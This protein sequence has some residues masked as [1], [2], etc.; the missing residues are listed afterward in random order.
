[1]RY[2]SNEITE[3]IKRFCAG[4][5]EAFAGIYEGTY[6]LVY[7]TCYG[8]IR[9]KD[10]A[11]DLTQDVFVQIYE[12]LG[13]LK[14]PAA[15]GKWMKLVAS[16]RAINF[17]NRKSRVS[18]VGDDHELDEAVSDW[19]EFDSLPDSFIEEEEKRD[20]INKV[21]KES[22]SDVQYQTLFMF[23][24]G[25]MPLAKIA[26]AMNCPEGTVKTR[27]LHAKNKFKRSL[28]GYLD[29]NRLVLAAVPFMTRFFNYQTGRLKLPPVPLFAYPGAAVDSAA[30]AANAGEAAAKAVGGTV[31]RGG[32]L[33]TAGGKIIA[34]GIALLVTGTAVVVGL[35]VLK[36]D[37]PSV[38]E[39]SV[40]TD[41]T[42]PRT[43]ESSGSAA[44]SVSDRVT[45]GEEMTFGQYGGEDIEWIVIDKD[46]DGYLLLS[47]YVLDARAIDYVSSGKWEFCTLRH[48]LN[49]DFYDQAFSMDEKCFIKETPLESD[50][51]SD[52]V[53]ILNYDEYNDLALD[54]RRVEPTQYA[55]DNGVWTSPVGNAAYWLRP[56]TCTSGE[57][58]VPD[59]NLGGLDKDGK[60]IMGDFVG[61]RPAVRL[62]YEATE[63]PVET[64]KSIREVTLGRYGGED[65]E[66]VVLE[67]NEDSLLV[68]SKY[69]LE[70]K[71]YNV[72]Y[73]AVTWE[74][75]D[76]RKWLNGEFY[77]EAFNAEEKD[78]IIKSTLDNPDNEICGTDGGNITEDN[79]F[80][81]SFEELQKYMFDGSEVWEDNR[82]FTPGQAVVDGALRKCELRTGYAT[83]YSRPH[84]PYANDYRVTWWLRTP[85]LINNYTM[86]VS[87]GSGV[88]AHGSSVVDQYYG[89]R[90]AMRIKRS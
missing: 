6:Q 78:R 45:V 23:Y 54:Y 44:E 53:F 35:N 68:I 73:E 22:L 62:S 40:S 12:K 39:P 42:I 66:W 88:N 36:K 82:I 11:E 85:G 15:Y 14:D 26:E 48:W 38:T 64:D 18:N 80:I 87:Y 83:D 47:K 30:A 56:N 51:T 2:D 41:L 25:E 86:N 8:I 32:F 77:D 24:Y 58:N 74:T 31:S 28:E 84:F 49:N 57:A 90:P 59:F 71:A 76:L 29:D 37:E 52:R 46:E 21:L 60:L 89:V 4:D 7:T 10:D 79:V 72:E 67:E 61:V 1:M 63:T 81:L 50:G 43:E 9:D 69:V 70:A 3:L 17:V 75:C 20:I 27:L 33:S 5:S 34:G 19:E 65:I 16:N 55:L 13:T